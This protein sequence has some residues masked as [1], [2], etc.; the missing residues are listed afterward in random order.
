[1]YTIIKKT[2]KYIRFSKKSLDKSRL[3]LYNKVNK[4]EKNMRYKR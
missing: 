1:M 3:F 2:K 4:R